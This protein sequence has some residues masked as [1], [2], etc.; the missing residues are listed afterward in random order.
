MSTLNVRRIELSSSGQISIEDDQ[1]K[2]HDLNPK[3]INHMSQ[4][5][6]NITLFHKNEQI[7]LKF[8]FNMDS[9]QFINTLIAQ[10]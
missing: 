4:S 5:G 8:P 2:S 6:Q 3:S 9:T 7:D 1:G 10:F